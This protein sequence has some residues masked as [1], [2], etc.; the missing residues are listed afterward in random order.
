VERQIERGPEVIGLVAGPWL[1]LPPGLDSTLGYSYWLIV[2]REPVSGGKSAG[3]E[4]TRE[5]RKSSF[6][7]PYTYTY[8]D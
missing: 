5:L 7:L 1:R 4:E 3:V 8:H 6:L 2:E